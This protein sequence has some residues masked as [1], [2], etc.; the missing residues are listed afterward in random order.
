MYRHIYKKD[1]IL[2]PMAKIQEK[3]TPVSNVRPNRNISVVERKPFL[4]QGQGMI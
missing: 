4:K 3:V 1:G 2:P